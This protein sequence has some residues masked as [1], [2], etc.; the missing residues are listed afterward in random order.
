MLHT[1]TTCASSH[2]I[3]MRFINLH[4]L[5][6]MV[7]M[8]RTSAMCAQQCC[9]HGLGCQTPGA[10]ETWSELQPCAASRCDAA[11]CAVLHYVCCIVLLRCEALC[12]AAPCCAA[13]CCA[14]L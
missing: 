13:L 4:A 8:T 9:F 5:G 12:R 11:C 14:V 7:S 2:T 3:P 10:A 6:G 1:S